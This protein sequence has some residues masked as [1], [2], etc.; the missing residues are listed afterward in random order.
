LL[1]F[2][3]MV[4][5]KPVSADNGLLS[6]QEQVKQHL[7]AAAVAVSDLDQ[8]I[9]GFERSIADTNQRIQQERLELRLLAR[10]MYAEPESPLM[11]AFAASSVAEALTR[12]SQ[13]TAAGDRAAATKNALDTDLGNLETQKATMQADRQQQEQMLQ[14]LDAQF[15]RLQGMSGTIA[16]AP[17]VPASAPV[18]KSAIQQI[19]LNAFAPLGAAAQAWALAVAKCESGYNPLAVNRSSGASGLFQFL[20]SS[21]ANTPQGKAGQSVFDANANALGAAWYYNATGRTGRPWSCK[22]P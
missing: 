4:L 16:A 1:L 12:F 2:A 14:Q 21:W 22:G 7:A 9:A 19:I 17:S 6:Q 18:A 13:L 11:A 15:K 5:A 10:T 20:P 8:R 3:F